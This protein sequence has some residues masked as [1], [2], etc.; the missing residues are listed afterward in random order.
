VA[1]LF[2]ESDAVR[3]A[4]TRL[5]LAMEDDAESLARAVDQL[6]SPRDTR[7]RKRTTPSVL[8]CHR[9]T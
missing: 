9:D 3:E 7:R 2:T 4:S 1:V 8:P 5:L 6:S